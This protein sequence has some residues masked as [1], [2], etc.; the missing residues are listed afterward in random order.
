MHD[1][2]VTPRAVCSRSDALTNVLV[3]DLVVLLTFE[4]ATGLGIVRAVALRRVPT[5]RV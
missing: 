2:G 5:G 4:G 1:L 3:I